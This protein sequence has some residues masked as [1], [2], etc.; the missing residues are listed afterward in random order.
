MNRVKTGF[1]LVELL[2]VIAIIGILVA[3][4]LPAIQAAREAA[5]RT[6]CN[7]KMKQLGI[8][9]HNYHDTFGTFMPGMFDAH[10][11]NE[12]R[13]RRKTWYMCVLPFV[14]QQGY[15]DTLLALEV[16]NTQAPFSWADAKTVVDGFVCP[17][18]SK[19]GIPDRNGQG[20]HGNYVL[21]WGSGNSG[22]AGNTNDLGGM[23]YSRSSVKMRD[24]TDGTSNTVMGSEVALTDPQASKYPAPNCGGDHDLRGRY[25]NGL[26]MSGLFTAIRPPNTVVGDRHNYCNNAPWA[27]CRECA[28]DYTEV[29]ARS[30]HPGGA[31]VLFADASVSFIS[32]DMNQ[33]TFQALGTRS[34]GEVPQ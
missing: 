6:E 11:Q 27:P 12:G 32:S 3:L 1:T 14:E 25:F 8:G 26:H 20:F 5:N 18:D 7:N 2:V 21:C 15:Y 33:G 13:P 28:G 34:G 17:S 9:L 19:G 4:L 23:F 22:P 16:A 24:V 10:Q 31:N 30:R 29:H